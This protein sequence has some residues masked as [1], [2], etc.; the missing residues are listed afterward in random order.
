MVAGEW[1]TMSHLQ[2]YPTPFLNHET[3]R[4]GGPL[5]L[6]GYIKLDHKVNDV[7]G[8]DF[9]T[10]TKLVCASDDDSQ[11]LFPNAKPLLEVDLPRPLN[12]ASMKGH[13]VDLG[14]IPQQSSCSGTFEAEGVD[15]DA[16][17][18]ILRLEV[19]QPSSCI[20][21]T[22]VYEYKQAHHHN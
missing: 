15:F 1:D 16:S 14:S 17:T 22:T 19:I 4:H 10:P 8:C 9:V 21:M 11:A 3:P 2:I 13:V 18:G 20:L 12:G 7:Q 6:A 5:K